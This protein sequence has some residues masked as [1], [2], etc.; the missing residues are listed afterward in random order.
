MTD[1]N[2][3]RYGLLV[4]GTGAIAAA[5]W[6]GYHPG[7]QLTATTST[8]TDAPT[9]TSLTPLTTLPPPSTISAPPALS[10]PPAPPLP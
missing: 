2:I 3:A 1:R 10:A 4:I 5:A 7:M 9:T 6:I 8:T